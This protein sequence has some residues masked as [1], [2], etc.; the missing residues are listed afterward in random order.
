MRNPYFK[1]GVSAT[2]DMYESI[3][4]QALKIYGQETVYL[5]REIVNR[6]TILSEDA[7]SRFEVGYPIEMYIENTEG[8][9]GEGD[10]FTKFGVEIRDEAT[11]VVSRRRFN[12]TIGTN[13]DFIRPREGDLVYLGLTG[14]VFEIM[15]VEA[16]NPFYQLSNLPTF[17]MYCEKFEYS[18]EDFDTNIPEL[19]EVLEQDTYTLNISLADSGSDNI[20][21]GSEAYQLV[22]SENG[23]RVTAEVVDWDAASNSI[24]LAHVGTPDGEF[25]EF[26]SGDI[27]FDNGVVKRVDTDSDIVED[28]AGLGEQNDF[29][30]E[31]TVDI[32][33]F[34]ETNPFGSF[35]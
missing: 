13:E 8:F 7:V 28:L 4:I 27:H 25:R 3:V 6:E 29:F 1:Q 10:L 30:E 26:G 12:Q 19:D 35:E 34:S 11:F 22:D 33:D 24:T 20:N 9:D 16:D 31:E 18:D 5:P 21:I 17:K 32:I 23:K 14:S 2:Q 15:R